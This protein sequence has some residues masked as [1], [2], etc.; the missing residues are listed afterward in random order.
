MAPISFA[1]MVGALR[2][3]QLQGMP[4][5]YRAYLPQ[6]APQHPED[7]N[8]QP[9]H[10]ED[11]NPHPAHPEDSYQ[12]D[13]HLQVD[14]GWLP[15]REDCFGGYNAINPSFTFI[16]WV[17]MK[18]AVAMRVLCLHKN[19]NHAIW[20][21][22]LLLGSTDINSIRKDVREKVEWS[23]LEL[24]PDPRT[25]AMNSPMV[26]CQIPSL[27]VAQ[28]P[29]DPRLVR[30]PAGLYVIVAG[31]AVV[32]AQPGQLER[33]V[34]GPQGFMLHAAKVESLSPAKFGPSVQLKFATMDR[35]EKNWGMFTSADTRNS[36]THAIYSVYPHKIATVDLAD[37][38]VRF[39]FE[40]WSTALVTLAHTLKVRP[41]DFHGGAG[42]AHIDGEHGY[43]LS[44]LHVRVFDNGRS[45]YWNFPYKFESHPPFAIT[46]IGQRMH[47][48]LKENPIYGGEVV[49][50]VTTLLYDQGDVF[51]GYGSGDR[52]ARTLRMSLTEF[53]QRF[54]PSNPPGVPSNPSG[55][56]MLGHVPRT[57]D[58]VS[59]K[60]AACQQQLYQEVCTDSLTP[61][62]CRACP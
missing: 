8:P 5:R 3:A 50:F 62:I 55:D 41:Q 25:A 58:H 17:P 7:S 13:Q 42:I 33:P 21:S 26:E 59:K 29:E 46:H 37:G 31:Y 61:S 36:T 39:D 30:T 48:M 12:E 15:R 43:Y 27:D 9:P 14:M 19:G 47:L 56:T 54:F 6:P 35:V 16:P 24:A 2:V 45:S 4:V 52:E 38:N 18:L 22:Q 11:S 32:A 10:P 20:L 57:G 23:S 1:I 40:T 60:P 49:A 34:C 28:G 44:I 53:E 51:V